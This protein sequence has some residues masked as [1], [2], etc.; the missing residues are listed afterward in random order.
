MKKR[1]NGA[2]LAARWGLS[3]Q[4]VHE[5]CKDGRLKRGVDNKFD[6]DEAG[7]VRAV[8]LAKHAD[9]ALVV[10]NSNR[11]GTTPP[12]AA[13]I[14]EDLTPEEAEL[15][16]IEPA[17]EEQQVQVSVK[18]AASSALQQTRLINELRAQKMK[19]EIKRAE[20]RAA[21]EAGLYVAKAEVRKHGAE[22]GK[23]IAALLGS[24]PTEIASIFSDP[25]T[26]DQVFAKVRERCDQMQHSVHKALTAAVP[27][28]AE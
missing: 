18:E 8:I 13:L 22:A 21:R 26:K 25:R 10:S 24:L 5:I 23:I 15:L 3:R 14:A 20:D 2:E 16:G 12:K 28:D 19:L 11:Y 4:R 6:V 27:D 17:V 7:Q 9:K 1:M